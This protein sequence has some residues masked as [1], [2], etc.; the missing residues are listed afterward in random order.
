M[1]QI[2]TPSTSH[3]PIK[4]VFPDVFYVQ[5]TVKMGPGVRITRSMVIIRENGGLSLINAIRLGSE[6]EAKL[7]KLGQVKH[8]LKIGSHGMDNPYYIDKYQPKIWSRKEAGLGYEPDV[9]IEENVELP[10]SNAM[11]FKFKN[12]KSPEFP[13]LLRRE[14]GIL[15]TCD[16]VQNWGK[17]DLKIGS[18]IGGLVT[19]AL[20]FIGPAKI[21]PIWLKTV[22]PES[23]PNLSLDF[24]RLLGLDF[25]HL[26]SGHGSPLFDDAKNTLEKQVKKVKF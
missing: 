11:V 20:G 5:G 9:M 22:T 6:D 3:G 4:E 10:F 26:L 14:G 18:F 19:R 21:G 12:A 25:K 23:G 17:K 8:L 15:I 1:S 24:E 16:S 2:Y 13:I 7:E